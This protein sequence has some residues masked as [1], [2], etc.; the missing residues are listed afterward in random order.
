MKR[1]FKVLALIIMAAIFVT[2][3]VLPVNLKADLLIPGGKYKINNTDT[4]ACSV[5]TN[6][7][8]LFMTYEEP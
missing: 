6:C 1:T 7:Q 5:G 3:I 4:C 8:C 2:L